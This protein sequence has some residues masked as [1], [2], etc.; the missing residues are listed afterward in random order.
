MNPADIPFDIS[1]AFDENLREYPCNAQ[2]M[3]R[4]L[5][6]I[7]ERLEAN[8]FEPHQHIRMAG[9][10][11][12]LARILRDFEIAHRNLEQALRLARIADEKRFVTANELR[13]AHLYQWEKQFGTSTTM[14]D[15][16]IKNCETDVELEAY[17]DFAYQHAGKNAFD[18][19]HYEEAE[20]FFKKALQIRSQKGNA[21]LIE[22]TELAMKA[23]HKRKMNAL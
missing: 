22:S 16:I 4:A 3:R 19:G 1:Y 6:W 21:D 10:A 23:V 17:L 15:E 18:Q 5:T 9:L 7:M 11:G 12:S 14:F 2:D 13:L 8:S 20:T